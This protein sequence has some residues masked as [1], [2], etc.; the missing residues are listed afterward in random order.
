M[1]LESH[2]SWGHIGVGVGVRVRLWLGSGVTLGSGLG[3]HRG[4]G[5]RWGHIGVGGHIGVRLG[6]G[7][8]RSPPTSPLELMRAVRRLSPLPHELC[9]FHT[10]SLGGL[11]VAPAPEAQI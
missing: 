5:S 9:A 1:W 2:W 3:S 8:A 4:R 7:S 10:T 6:S 11:W